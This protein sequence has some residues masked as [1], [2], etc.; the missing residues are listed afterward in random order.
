M[1]LIGYARVS[2]DSQ[3]LEPQLSELRNAGCERIFSESASGARSN[4]AQLDAALEYMREGDVLVVVAIDRLSRSILQTVLLFEMLN[5]RGL[6][7]KSLSQ[8]FDTTT[9]EGRMMMQVMAAIAELERAF[10]SRRTLA[11]LANAR[12]EGVRLGRPVVLTDEVLRTLATLYLRE[13]SISEMAT[14]LKISQ[15]SVTRGLAQL[16]AQ[17]VID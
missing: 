16:R 8:P 2:T 9:P 6:G 15:R 4:R 17:K 3:S 10:I 11:G 13:H 14:T 12:A 7:F 5:S 1:A